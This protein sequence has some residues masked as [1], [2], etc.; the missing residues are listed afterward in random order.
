MWSPAKKGEFA[1]TNLVP[2]SQIIPT[3]FFFVFFARQQEAPW[4][5]PWQIASR[6][7]LDWNILLCEYVQ[8]EQE[9]TKTFQLTSLRDLQPFSR[10]NC[11][12]FFLRQLG[13]KTI[14]MNSNIFIGTVYWNAYSATLW[15]SNWSDR[16]FVL[17]DL[18]GKLGLQEC[19]A[20]I[21]LKAIG[22][23]PSLIP[24]KIIK[25]RS[26]NPQGQI[27]KQNLA[28]FAFQAGLKG[29]LWMWG[30]VTFAFNVKSPSLRMHGWAWTR[31]WTK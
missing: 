31:K 4:Q 18:N 5:V 20:Y 22:Q 9:Q 19:Q 16:I 28:C 24:G 6:T 3:F 11:F 25:G 2:S 14:K 30:G 15:K 23:R 27:R 10:T 21:C 17:P 13:A 26:E 1:K 8:Q 7:F 12:A 29:V